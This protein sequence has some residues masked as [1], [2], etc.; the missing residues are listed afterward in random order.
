[1]NNLIEICAY[2]YSFYFILLM[3]IT[4]LVRFMGVRLLGVVLHSG[5]WQVYNKNQIKLHL[6]NPTKSNKKDKRNILSACQQYRDWI[7]YSTKLL[8]YY[9]TVSIY[10]LC[11]TVDIV[12]KDS[13]YL[14]TDSTVLVVT[15]DRDETGDNQYLSVVLVSCDTPLYRVFRTLDEVLLGHQE[16]V[17]R[18]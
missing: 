18:Q 16:V 3:N 10:V 4:L 1:M 8:L 13:S 7:C 12:F 9:I 5:R 6:K 14:P 15:N 11:A 2:L 17:H